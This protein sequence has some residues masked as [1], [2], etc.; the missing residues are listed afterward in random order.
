M[1]LIFCYLPCITLLLDMDVLNY[2]AS[3]G[4][5]LTI[6]LFI[7]I[8]ALSVFVYRQWASNKTLL[9]G[10]QPRAIKEI[11]LEQMGKVGELQMEVSATSQRVAE[12]SQ[13]YNISIQKV[14]LVRFSAFDDT[15]GDQ[16]FALALLDANNSGIIL[17]A[18]HGRDRTR[19]YAKAIHNGES[20]G[21]AL[22]GE[23]KEAIEQAVR[24]D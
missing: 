16:S 9:G 14:G 17:S 3:Y 22:S 21:Y 5:V 6:I 20:A 12:V 7:W 18:L 13:A 4:S 11:V 24:G 23:E 10:K 19:M 15:G 1:R 8:S 2:L